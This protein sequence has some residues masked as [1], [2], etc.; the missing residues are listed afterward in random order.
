MYWQKPETEQFECSNTP[1]YAL[2][3]IQSLS[4]YARISKCVV[5]KK[6]HE[7]KKIN[8]F[9]FSSNVELNE[10]RQQKQNERKRNASIILYKSLSMYNNG[11]AIDVVVVVAVMSLHSL[12]SQNK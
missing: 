7:N 10:R 12:Y 4:L 1:Q 5:Q 6:I 2:T 11:N 8:I 9:F 3:R